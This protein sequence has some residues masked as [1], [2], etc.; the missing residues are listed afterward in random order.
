M[1][2]QPIH[3][4]HQ[5]NDRS[6]LKYMTV[7]VIGLLCGL[8]LAYGFYGTTLLQEQADTSALEQQLAEAYIEKTNSLVQLGYSYGARSLA[9]QVIP[10]K[11]VGSVQAGDETIKVQFADGQYY[12]LKVPEF[13]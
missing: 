12:E 3:P 11:T 9:A 10:A 8:G 5:Q 6:F 13:Q 7:L 4:M 2:N 1:H